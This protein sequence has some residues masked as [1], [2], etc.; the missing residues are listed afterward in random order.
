MSITSPASLSRAIASGGDGDGD[1]DASS[2][3]G[4][5]WTRGSPLPESGSMPLPA[6]GK[7]AERR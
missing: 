6:A 2:G 7:Q 5:R 3:S 1:V 4:H